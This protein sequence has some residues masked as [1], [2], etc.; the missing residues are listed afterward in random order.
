[1]EWG[2]SLKKAKQQ[3]EQTWEVGISHVL[4]IHPISVLNEIRLLKRFYPID[5]LGRVT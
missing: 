5:L 4:S 2:I 1:M 3:G